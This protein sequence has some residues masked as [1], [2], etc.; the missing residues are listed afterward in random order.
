MIVLVPVIR[1]S[2][3]AADNI[4]NDNNWEYCASNLSN[5]IC[6]LHCSDASQAY[7][8]YYARYTK[9]SIT[10]ESVIIIIIIKNNN[11]YK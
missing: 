8:D 1:L 5:Y 4:V 6:K 3:K 9:C 7:H 2:R 11:L 10:S